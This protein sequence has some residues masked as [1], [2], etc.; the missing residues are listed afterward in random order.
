MCTVHIE[1]N[2]SLKSIKDVARIIMKLQSFLFILKVEQSNSK[3]TGQG[4][5]FS[6]PEYNPKMIALL[7]H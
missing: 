5:G 3:K 2:Y 1:L 7:K 4:K 6:C